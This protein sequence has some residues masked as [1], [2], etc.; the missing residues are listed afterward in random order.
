MRGPLG[1][2]HMPTTLILLARGIS[3][4]C[5]VMPLV[6]LPQHVGQAPRA[7]ISTERAEFRF[8]VDTQRLYEWDTLDS[9]AY[10]DR[11]DYS[12]EVSWHPPYVR[13]GYDPDALWI[14]VRWRPGGP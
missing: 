4:C 3:A 14:V 8:P 12:W 11:S 9:L 10:P 5:L 6:A 1:V 7:T 13:F 2:A